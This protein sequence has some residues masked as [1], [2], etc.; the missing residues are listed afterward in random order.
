MR[1]VFKIVGLALLGVLVIGTFVF[2]YKK[3]RP[4]RKTYQIEIVI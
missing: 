4:V 2:L 3:S 1:K